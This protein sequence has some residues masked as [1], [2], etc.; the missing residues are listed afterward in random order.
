M[1]ANF[2]SSGILK[3]EDGELRFYPARPVDLRLCGYSERRRLIGRAYWRAPLALQPIRVLQRALPKVALDRSVTEFLAG[4]EVTPPDAIESDPHL[5]PFQK[6]AVGFLVTRPASLLALAPG[7]GKT[8]CA[9]KAAQYSGKRRILVVAPLSLLHN[10]RQEIARFWPDAAA[11]ILRAG[12]EFPALDDDRPAFVITNYEAARLRLVEKVPKAQALFRARLPVP[13][14]A[15]VLDESIMVKNREAQ[16]TKA[17]QAIRQAVP[18]V[19]ALSGNPA[20]RFL[21]DLW[22]QMHILDPKI[23]S[24]Y[25]RWAETY[26]Y[27]EKT[28]WG[29]KVTANR[30]DAA[31]LVAQDNQDFIF[32]M[33][34]EQAMPELPEI[35]FQDLAIPMAPAQARL[36]EQLRQEFIARLP[37]GRVIFTPNILAQMTRLLQVSSN[38]VLIGGPDV[39]PKWDAAI[40]LLEIVERP[41]VLWVNFVASAQALSESLRKKRYRVAVLTGAEHSAQARQD[42]VACFQRGELDVLVAHPGVGKFGFNLTAA[43]TAIYVERSFNG[44]DFYQS[45]HR[46]R[47]IGTTQPPLAI[48]LRAVVANN[49]R[50]HGIDNLVH[51]VLSARLEFSQALTKEVMNIWL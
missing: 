40:E 19:W 42:I 24:S 11:V 9:I 30:P 29:P 27:I 33:T 7:L 5:Y 6:R 23:Y 36:Y 2:G 14:D 34:I 49:H 3:V 32:A 46:M 43:R 50:E 21:D 25:W 31:R 1:F 8:I 38:P 20:S 47:R 45:L 41:A 26:C 37:D 12:D 13:F 17:I 22:A 48:L 51:Q 10:W 35:V 4:L 28:P 44:D 15:L 16:R 18:T 39:S